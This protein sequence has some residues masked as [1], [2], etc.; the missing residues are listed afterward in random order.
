MVLIQVLIYMFLVSVVLFGVSWRATLI[1]LW[2][3]KKKHAPQNHS[4]STCYSTYCFHFY[5]WK[6]LHFSTHS[7]SSLWAEVCLSWE[8]LALAV[9][10]LCAV[11]VCSFFTKGCKAG[12][13]S[14]IWQANK[15]HLDTIR[16][17]TAPWF[18]SS[19]WIAWWIRACP[20]LFHN[21][22]APKSTDFQQGQN[23]ALWHMDFHLVITASFSRHEIH[24]LQ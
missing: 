19:C 16:K 7:L 6:I 13:V 4:P 1:L 22:S 15:S 5:P 20:S 14:R 8:E 11:W 2:L 12:H 18:G 24:V 9:T 3:S 21:S 23:Q 10:M 17:T